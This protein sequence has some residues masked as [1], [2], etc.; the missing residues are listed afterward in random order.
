MR[1]PSSMIKTILS[2]NVKRSVEEPQYRF[3]VNQLLRLNMGFGKA[4]LLNENPWPFP[5]SKEYNLHIGCGPNVLDG[6]VNV[7]LFPANDRVQSWDL[8]SPWPMRI[9]GCIKKIFSEDVFEHFYY[10]EQCYLMCSA[11]V[12]LKEKSVFRV[13][14]PNVD[15]LVGYKSSFDAQNKEDWYV[16]NFGVRTG[17]DLLNSGMRFWGH[18]W[19]H[20]DESLG[21]MATGCGFKKV[22]TGLFD[23]IDPELNG[24]NIRKE[25]N[26]MAFANDLVKERPLRYERIMPS[27]VYGATLEEQVNPIQYLYRSNNDDP[28]VIYE[29]PRPISADKV[30]C[31]NV[32]GMNFS[33]FESRQSEIFFEG[34]RDAHF[35]LDDQ[36]K[37]HLHNNIVTFNNIEHKRLNKPVSKIRYDPGRSANEYFS[38]GPLEIFYYD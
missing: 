38:I 34:S 17:A 36:L 16:K 7:D 19:L 23:S 12:A 15:A 32:F 28:R 4:F 37:T 33:H 27:V 10:D 3:S 29:L 20:N 24:L 22:S 21:N 6:F 18:R 13:L 14:T 30:A 2:H 8:L 5:D 31:I 11:N 25:D 26:V 9:H 1:S 35:V